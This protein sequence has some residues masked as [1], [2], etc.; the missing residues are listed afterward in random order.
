MPLHRTE[1]DGRRP[2]DPSLGRATT[3]T[4]AEHSLSATSVDAGVNSSRSN[5]GAVTVGV[6]VGLDGMRR[7]LRL[8]SGRNT[9][10]LVIKI[11][12]DWA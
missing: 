3:A 7:N 1:N 9:A 4:G 10:H 8:I 11:T 12:T 2:G 5:H 6:R